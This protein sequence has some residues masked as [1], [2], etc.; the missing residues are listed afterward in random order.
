MIL[1]V[2]R[3]HCYYG[4]SHVL[5]GVTLNVSEGEIVSIL[6]RNGAGKS[7]TIQAIMGLVK[8]QSGSI[9]IAGTT[10]N[11]LPPHDICR[12]GVGWVPQGRRIF[13]HLTVEENLRVATFKDSKGRQRALDRAQTLFPILRERRSVKASGLS[14][15]EQQMLAIARAL[16][17]SPRI[18]LLDEPSEG[19][20]PP[21]IREVMKVV[22]EISVQGTAVLLA[23]QNIRAALA[24]AHRHY[25]MD[26]GEVPV[27]MT[28][29]EIQKRDDLLVRYLGVA[30][31]M[32][33]ELGASRKGG[34]PLAENT[35]EPSRTS[36]EPDRSA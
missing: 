24:T 16:I 12:R 15:G 34:Q 26:K 19:L 18:L 27:A 5:R 36:T 13:P 8:V 33:V 9:N 17:G 35:P 32:P 1:S 7:T 22:G 14:G 2:E 29:K 6:G 11:G 4:L 31:R 23:E 28:T 10:I 3:L 20:S 30:A 25:L 21:A